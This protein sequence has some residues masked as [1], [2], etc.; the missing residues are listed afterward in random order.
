MVLH[1]P[2]CGDNVPEGSSFCPHCGA[3]IEITPI[4][5]IKSSNLPLTGGI[6]TIIDACL[7]LFIGI[8]GVLRYAWSFYNYP[9]LL[10]LGL[11]AFLGFAFGLVGGIA[12]LKKKY[13]E[14]ALL[15]TSVIMLSGFVDVIAFAAARHRAFLEAALGIPVLILAI[16]SL[17]F[18][19]ISRTEFD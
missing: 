12:A 4:V 1:C 8:V 18:I 6:L 15:G 16:L 2:K 3:P 17:V 10:F 7:C 9:W 5:K 13:Y 14:I 11:T 19:A